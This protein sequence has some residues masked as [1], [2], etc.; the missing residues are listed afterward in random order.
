MLMWTAA[1]RFWNRDKFHGAD[2]LKRR[3]NPTRVPIEKEE[4][5]RW[6]ENLRQSTELLADPGRC[7]PI[8]DRESVIYDGAGG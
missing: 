3:V 5:I 4:S 1:S 2:A 7:V 8:G 6:P